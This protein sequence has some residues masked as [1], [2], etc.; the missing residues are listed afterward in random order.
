M[1]EQ[2]V[3]IGAN[4]L[5]GI[6]TEPP[7][8]T[9]DRGERPGVILLNSGLIQRVGPNRLYVQLARRLAA[10]GHIVLRFDLSAIG[11]SPRRPDNMPFDQSS[12]TE[13]QEAMDTLSTGWGLSTFVLAGIC[14][15][16]VVAFRT[17]CEEEAV[18]GVGMINAQGLAPGRNPEVSQFLNQRQA[19]NYY[20]TR[21]LFQPHSWKKLVAG[22]ADVGAI[23]RACGD[24]VSRL[25]GQKPSLDSPEAQQ[26]AEDL[27]DL[28]GT[29]RELLLL[30]SEGDPGREELEL[31]L[32]SRKRD[33]KNAPGITLR[34]VSGADHM[35]TP[36]PKQRAFLD[37]LAGWVEGVGRHWEAPVTGLGAD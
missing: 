3:R 27:L 2:T 24:R 23:A 34:T 8:G 19:G 30:Y 11:D 37:E 29:D 7:A 9:A 13:T 4:R 6:V 12:V 5:V 15:G 28:A 22:R 1:R 16:A 26:V 17:A 10:Q 35:F 20:L 36:L 31:L 32:R 18:K 14:T 21:A 33:L 25:M